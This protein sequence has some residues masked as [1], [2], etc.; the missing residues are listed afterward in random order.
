M[1][2]RRAHAGKLRGLEELRGLGDPQR[3]SR[4]RRRGSPG[5]L[6]RTL[7][8]PPLCPLG[9][10]AGLGAPLR[11]GFFPGLL[12]LWPRARPHAGCDCP[13][14]IVP[15][16]EPWR[17]YRARR[18]RRL[19]SLGWGRGTRE[20]A[21]RDGCGSVGAAGTWP[22]LDRGRSCGLAPGAGL[23]RK[24]QMSLGIAALAPPVAGGLWGEW[25]AEERGFHAGG[26]IVR[27]PNSSGG[28]C[29]SL[30]ERRWEHEGDDGPVHFPLPVFHIL[31]VS[32]LLHPCQFAP[33]GLVIGVG[34][35]C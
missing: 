6:A 33:S 16:G 18:P 14:Q 2:A 21:A 9:G 30:P 20:P 3:L 25:D 1:C 28:I 5:A 13:D 24:R 32:L 29:K 35:R 7:A 26:P 19:G 22:G 4:V 23:K 31:R 11:S 27:L 8:A 17:S 12:R 15:L 34:P 10:A